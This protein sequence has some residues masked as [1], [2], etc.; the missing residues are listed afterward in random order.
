M[1]FKLYDLLL[2]HTLSTFLSTF[3]YLF[4]VVLGTELKALYLL[5]KHCT[6]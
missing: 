4:L 1:T 6:T 3:S 5:H 2:N